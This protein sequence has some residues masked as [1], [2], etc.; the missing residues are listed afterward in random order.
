MRWFLALL[1]WVCAAAAVAASH[2]YAGGR[3]GGE[4]V[5]FHVHGLAFSSD[6]KAILVPS[7]YGLAAYRD[8]SWSEVDGPIHDFAGFSVSESAIYASG[9]PP[10]GSALPDPLGLV[11]STNSGETW[12]SLALGGEVDFH[13]IAAG[14]RSKAIYVLNERPNSA[15]PAAGLYLTLDEGKTWRYGAARGLEGKI[16]GLAAHPRE[17]EI[18]VVATDR[19]LYLSRDAGGRFSRLDRGAV[20]AVT[21]DPEGKRLY[22]ARAI[23]RELISAPLDSRVRSL[24][25][26]PRLGLDY[27]THVTQHP[28]DERS[29][30]I[31]TD[32]RHVYITN[33]GGSKWRQIAKDGDLP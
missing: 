3:T 27:V 12:R 31:A 32:R 16:F 15:M 6:G 4:P 26:L 11:K 17:A 14:Y 22:Y 5:L 28:K 7:H 25:R 1:A 20:T 29:M 10:Q 21:F 30:A 24:I 23:R 8:G 2:T 33:D 9:H 13:L 19:G 18:L